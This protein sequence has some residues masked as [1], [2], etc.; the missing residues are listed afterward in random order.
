MAGRILAAAAPIMLAV[1]VAAGQQPPEARVVS[2][3]TDTTPVAVAPRCDAPSIAVNAYANVRA[4][5]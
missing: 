5:Q 1:H 3:P 4:P 2:P